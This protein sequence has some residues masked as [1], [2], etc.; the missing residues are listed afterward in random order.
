MVTAAY[1]WVRVA[2]VGFLRTFL[3]GAWVRDKELFEI[4]MDSYHKI[5]LLQR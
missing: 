3:P 2:Q 5:M 4:K 1:F